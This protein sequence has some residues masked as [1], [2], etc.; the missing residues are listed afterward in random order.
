MNPVDDPA[1]R[2]NH[3]EKVWS[4]SEPHDV[5]WY[6][7]SPDI[8][9]RLIEA[10]GVNREAHIVD[11]GGGFSTLVDNLLEQ[12]FENISVLD[13]S[14]SAIKHA[15]ARLGALS[16]RASWIV[17]DVMTFRADK[18]IELWHDRA[19]LHFMTDK[20]ELNLYVQSFT[21]SVAPNGH[22]IIA[23]FALDGPTK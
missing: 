5:S 18:P 7:E 10:T 2:K 4:T 20:R 19:V 15:Q 3:W 23:T 12:S 22:A 21:E 17:G 11:V 6:Q 16:R 1:K 13:V 14:M 9:L 8:S